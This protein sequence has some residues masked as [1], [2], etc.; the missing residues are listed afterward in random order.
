VTNCGHVSDSSANVYTPHVD[1][2]ASNGGRRKRTLLPGAAMSIA[3]RYLTRREAELLDI[4]YRRGPATAVE[5]L[6]E[7]EDSRNYSTVRTQLRVLEQKGHIKRKVSRGRRVYSAKVPTTLAGGRA[8]RHLLDTFFDGSLENAVTFALKSK[9]FPLSDD[10]RDRLIT[11]CMTR[12]I[13]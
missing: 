12:K 5:I 1:S 7:C 10:A 2:S 3:H 6:K 11:L 13:T 8:F 9:S 4:L